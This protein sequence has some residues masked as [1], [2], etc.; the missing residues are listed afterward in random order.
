MAL[1][2]ETADLDTT[3]IPVPIEKFASLDVLSWSDIL[4]HKTVLEQG[5][6]EGNAPRNTLLFSLLCSPRL[7]QSATHKTIIKH[8][9]EMFAH[10][11]GTLIF[12]LVVSIPYFVATKIAFA[13]VPETNDA[14]TWP[15]STLAGFQNSTVFNP[16]DQSAVILRVPFISAANWEPTNA[17]TGQI[18]AKLLDPI[19]S[20]LD[21]SGGIPWT[22]FVSADPTDF[23]FRYVAPPLLQSFDAT[24][25]IKDEPTLTDLTLARSMSTAPMNQL[26]RATQSWP[27]VQQV[28][29][30]T[31][32][33]YETMMLIPRSRVEFVIQKIRGQFPTGLLPSSCVLNMFDVPSSS[34]SSYTNVTPPPP[35]TLYPYLT[36]PFLVATGS[37]IGDVG[38]P[39]NSP[40]PVQILVHNTHID[41]H[42]M[43]SSHAQ[44]VLDSSPPNMWFNYYG[45]IDGTKKWNAMGKFRFVQSAEVNG[46]FYHSYKDAG[47][48]QG[49]D[50][51]AYVSN[52]SS[53][54]A[55]VCSWASSNII[56]PQ[57]SYVIDCLNQIESCPST[58][59]HLALYTNMPPSL[60]STFTSW[61]V[62]SDNTSP[63]AEALSYSISFSPNQSALAFNGGRYS[64]YDTSR[65]I[66]WRL[67]KLFKG[68]ETKWWAWLVKGLDIVVDALIGAF[69]GRAGSPYVVP[70]GLGSGFRAEAVG[71][72]SDAQI[73]SVDP[74]PLE[75]I[76]PKKAI[77]L[78]RFAAES[79]NLSQPSR[80]DSLAASQPVS[81]ASTKSSSRFPSRKHRFHQARHPSKRN[82]L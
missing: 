64:E 66:V 45:M 30:N 69:L 12:E 14:D 39:L 38:I 26:A 72:Y 76:P 67:F 46:R 60:A 34:L 7:L 58:V 49:S 77:S 75:Y 17:S 74:V 48:V 42:F 79:Q 6:L 61:L 40:A 1:K 21:L 51:F 27:L 52:L 29:T 70:I 62:T 31:R 35:D 28:S 15:A 22:L 23:S 68:D 53:I 9:A 73:S 44:H 50:K 20:S 37:S 13:F 65:G 56:S 59:T 10:W 63:P 55:C 43:V 41:L 11:H 19:V 54:E 47:Y 8:L 80:A 57:S 81:R 18:V 5:V 32:N 71:A 82:F 36:Q 24:P 2:P 25:G 3:S 33:Q 16:T 4:S 78:V